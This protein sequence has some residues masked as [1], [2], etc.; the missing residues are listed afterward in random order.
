MSLERSPS[1]DSES[2]TGGRSH[3][4][5]EFCRLEQMSRAQLYKLWSST[6]TL[7]P[8]FYYVG[9]GNTH[10]RISEQAR[11]DWHRDREAAAAQAR[12]ITA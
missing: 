2:G 4:V 11:H 10:R 6:P 9:T 1:R 8:R 12:E 3:T 7:G 5:A